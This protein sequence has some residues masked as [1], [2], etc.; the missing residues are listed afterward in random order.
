[1]SKK[2]FFLMIL[3]IFCAPALL[4]QVKIAYINSEQIIQQLPEAQE[5]QK[6][7]EDMQKVTIDSMQLIEKDFQTKLADY[8]QQESLMNEDAKKKKQQ[9]LADLQSR[10]GQYRQ[11]K[12]DEIGKKRDELMRPIMEKIQK[13][14]DQLAKEEN[15]N[16][17]FDKTAA[18]PVLLYGDAEYNLTNKLLDTMIRGVKPGKKK[19][20]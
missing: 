12:T 5:A 6:L 15:L 8:Q 17:I 4:S 2:V 11:K 20:K 3:G 7:L 18:I 16:F 10:Y 19:G 9:E 1:M 13:A 14:I